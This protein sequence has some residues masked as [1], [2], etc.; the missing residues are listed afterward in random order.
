MSKKR[1]KGLFWYFVLNDI[2]VWLIMANSTDIWVFMPDEPNPDNVTLLRML[3]DIFL[4]MI[5][6]LIS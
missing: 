2:I 3:W 5:H 4:Q 6:N 1:N